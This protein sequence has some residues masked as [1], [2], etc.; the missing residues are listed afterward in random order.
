MACRQPRRLVINPDIQFVAGLK[1]L[2]PDSGIMRSPI[3]SHF[4]SDTAKPFFELLRDPEAFDIHLAQAGAQ[5]GRLSLGGQHYHND[6]RPH[7]REG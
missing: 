2:F 5:F 7:Q 1:E 4:I 6:Q 3:G